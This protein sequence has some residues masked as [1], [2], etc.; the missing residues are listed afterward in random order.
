LKFIGNV[1]Y[2]IDAPTLK[3]DGN[4]TFGV[5]MLP[6]FTALWGEQRVVGT[7]DHVVIIIGQGVGLTAHTKAP[8]T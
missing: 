6:I 1:S 7:K 4:L 3:K 2:S 8:S 5:V